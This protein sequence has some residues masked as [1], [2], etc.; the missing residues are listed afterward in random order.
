MQVAALSPQ[1][2]LSVYDWLFNCRIHLPAMNSQP[3]RTASATSPRAAHG[4]VCPFRQTILMSLNPKV[5]LAIFCLPWQLLKMCRLSTYVFLYLKR[6]NIA[7]HI[8]S[9]TTVLQGDFEKIHANTSDPR[10]SEDTEEVGL[11]LLLSLPV[12][13]L[14]VFL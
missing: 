2:W 12:P 10:S 7:M 6:Q 4:S 5:F 11:C 8:C 9:Y 14:S 13:Y 3:E 1:C